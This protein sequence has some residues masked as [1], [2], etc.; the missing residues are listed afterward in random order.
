MAVSGRREG[1]SLV[2][3]LSKA[4]DE[5]IDISCQPC[6]FEGNTVAAEGYCQVCNEYL[7][8]TCLSVHQKQSATRSHATLG[9]DQ[10]AKGQSQRPY[11]CY[12]VC[13]IHVRE[14]VK[15][16]CQSHDSVGCGDCMVLD[17]NS[18]E[19]DLV[20]DISSVFT[21][22]DEQ[23]EIEQQFD[24]FETKLSQTR[25]QLSMSKR[26]IGHKHSKVLLDIREFRK[27][28]N[29]HLDKM[30]AKLI[31]EA[32]NA[33]QSAIIVIEEF[34][35]ELQT[36]LNEVNDM[37]TEIA[38]K[39]DECNELF[40]SIKQ[41]KAHIGNIKRAHKDMNSE[42]QIQGFQFQRNNDIGR[43]LF[44]CTALGV[45]QT[46]SK[47]KPL[48][49]ML[50]SIMD[51]KGVYA[52]TITVNDTNDI[53][54]CKISGMVIV[55]PDELVC[56]D[57][58]SSRTVKLICLKNNE[59][60]HAIT[61]DHNPFD[62][63][64]TSIQKDQL[65][66][67]LPKPNKIIFV[68]VSNGILSEQHSISVG[69]ECY[70]ICKY[71]DGL[72]VTYCSPG[73]VELLDISGNVTRTIK[74]NSNGQHLFS[75]PLYIDFCPRSNNIFVGDIDK[76]AVIKVTKD[77]EMTGQ[78]QES[79]WPQGIFVRDDGNVIVALY[80]GDINVISGDCRKLKRL[81]ERSDNEKWPWSICYNY[82]HSQLYVSNNNG[83]CINVYNIH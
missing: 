52:G 22:A 75:K 45:L 9:K 27:E 12:R 23:G 78:Y 50:T 43:V 48:P 60:K 2:D 40:V 8:R 61:L 56:V 69:G 34:T 38:A 46:S 58:R 11:A 35:T 32:E 62:I 31:A 41:A 66:I 80:T 51:M 59:T 63:T 36:L 33:T 47:T 20:A 37:R 19:V 73:S 39:A 67:T 65:A 21:S 76:N 7:C 82:Q 57:N 71:N 10:M 18:C 25:E 81:V 53:P 64:C 14:I 6:L 70:G 15:F 79:V 54:T 1:G 42:M 55:S 17:H 44:G 24:L 13:K 49:Q 83:R 3:S 26:D 68:S 30:E 16:Y 77:G 74:T 29:D 5:D 4:S 28:I 72:A